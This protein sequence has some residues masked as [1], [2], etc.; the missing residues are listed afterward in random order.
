MGRGV[1]KVRGNGLLVGVDAVDRSR[2]RAGGH[3]VDEDHRSLPFPCVH[4]GGAFPGLLQDTARMRGVCADSAGGDSA[5]PVVPAE[6]VAEP[7]DEGRGG[8]LH[9]G[10]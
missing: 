3:G 7:D 2:G 9:G 10:R 6:E 1:E 8:R 4:Q 5:R